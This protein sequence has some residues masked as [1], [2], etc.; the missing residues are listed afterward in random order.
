MLNLDLLFFARIMTFQVT[1][2]PWFPGAR[3]ESF[4]RRFV[5]DERSVGLWGKPFIIPS[6]KTGS[7]EQFGERYGLS[8]FGI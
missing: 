7:G 2:A 8:G 3:S 1:I 6:G 4:G 5:C